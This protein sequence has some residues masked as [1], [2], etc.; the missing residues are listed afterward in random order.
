MTMHAKMAIK[1]PDTISDIST[2]ASRRKPMRRARW[3]N[4]RIQ[5][6][7]QITQSPDTNIEIAVSTKPSV[8]FRVMVNG[9]VTLWAGEKE[10]N[11]YQLIGMN[12]TGN[13]TQTRA[14]L[15]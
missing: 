3:N 11:K 14:V 15:R 9:T 13:S 10:K 2:V 4:L 12:R 6:N 7:T 5:M 1:M 8:N